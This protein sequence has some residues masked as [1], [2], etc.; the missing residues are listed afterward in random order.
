MKPIGNFHLVSPSQA[1]RHQ[2]KYCLVGKEYK[3]I[4]R[5]GRVSR[6]PGEVQQ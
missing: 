4:Q 1:V 2:L 6:I 5:D 3:Q